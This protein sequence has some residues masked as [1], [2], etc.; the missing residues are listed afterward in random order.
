LASARTALR[1]SA[2]DDCSTLCLRQESSPTG[3]VGEFERFEVAIE[4]GAEIGERRVGHVALLR[5]LAKA[6]ALLPQREKM[7]RGRL[8]VSG[9]FLG[10]C[11][12]LR[13][14]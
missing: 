13:A 5:W 6:R 10:V 1:A 8:L 9:W 3:G 14:S 7:P 4:Q 2:A 12:R 11:A